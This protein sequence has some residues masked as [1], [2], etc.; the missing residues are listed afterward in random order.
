MQGSEAAI[1]FISDNAAPVAPKIMAALQRANEGAALSYGNDAL[2]Q[3]LEDRFRALFECDL[4]VFPVATGTAANVLGISSFTPPYG[5]IFCHR[6]AHIENDECGAPEFYTGGAKL[7][8]LDG[9]D[10]KLSPDAL[11]E[12]ILQDG[13]SVHHVVPSVISITQASE[14]GTV[15]RP[16]EIEDIARLVRRHGLILHM[17]GARFG[18]A[19]EFLGSHP[20][21]LTW[22]AG[23]DVLSFGA[24]KNGAMGAEAVVFFNME[25]AR[26][27]EFRR[28]R[29]GHLFSKMRYLG[30]QI[31]ASLDGDYWRELAAGA[32]RQAARLA[33]RL[34]Q[35]SGAEILYPVEANMIFVKLPEAVLARLAASNILYHR[36]ANDRDG[37][38]RLV[39]SWNTTEAEVEAL[40]NVIA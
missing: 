27:F 13:G 22:R 28:K 30:A 19:L 11:E 5:A 3:G 10:G 32:N 8:V 18:N 38:I 29:G 33:E 1:N 7:V 9:P 36:R 31:D 23:V 21:D 34:T 37:V 15:Y 24:T 16:G 20:A 26:E 35:V 2:T 12:A 40:V 6:S 39:T 25:K 17:D 4:K 14:C